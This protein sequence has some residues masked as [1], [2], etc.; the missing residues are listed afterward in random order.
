[1]TNPKTVLLAVA[2]VGLTVAAAGSA[3]AGHDNYNHG[4]GHP[5]A[6]HR[7]QGPVPVD[8]RIHQLH[9]GPCN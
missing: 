8:Y 5:A 6:L 2:A 3:A 7:S 9:R 1:M 4:R